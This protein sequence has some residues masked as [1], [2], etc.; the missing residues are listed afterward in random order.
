MIAEP[1]PEIDHDAILNALTDDSDQTDEGIYRSIFNRHIHNAL[2]QRFNHILFRFHID[3]SNQNGAYQP[4]QSIIER[5]CSYKIANKTA[6]TSRPIYGSSSSSSSSS[7]SDD[8]GNANMS[9]IQQRHID[10]I[11]QN[12]KAMS[13][14]SDPATVPNS[15]E[16]GIDVIQSNLAAM[17]VDLD[18]E[19][20]QMETTGNFRKI[21]ATNTIISN[22]S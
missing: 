1:L 4:S 17:E 19:G 8:D 12:L 22:F 13:E 21:K 2:N 7:D 20:S 11:E 3:E 9:P 14:S 15:N 6:S 5:E 18:A 16:D 10:L